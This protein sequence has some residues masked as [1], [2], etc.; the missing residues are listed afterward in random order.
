[1]KKTY[2]TLEFNTILSLI[3]EYCKSEQAKLAITNV[4]PITRYD[5]LI[6]Q[7]K[8]MQEAMDLIV[9]YGR[10]PIGPFYDISEIL[11]KANKDGT[12]AGEDFVR[13]RYQLDNV[14]E[15]V[16][17]IED[18]E[19]EDTTLYT[20]ITELYFIND[21]A[22]QITHCIDASGNVL[23]TASS[24][25]RRIRRA[26]L[27]TEANIRN[28]IVEMQ[29]VYK[30]LLSQETVA[31]RNNHLVLPVKASNKNNVKGIVHA[32]SASGQTMFIEPEAVAS[33][34]NQ[35]LHLESEEKQEVQRILFLLSQLVKQ[36][37][38]ILSTN[39]ELLVE[40]DVLFAKAMYGFS[41][42]G[43][44]PVIKE[45]GRS[46]RLQQARHPLIDKNEVVSNDIIISEDK[47]LLLISGSNTGGKTVVLK[48]AGLL[49]VMA[50]SGLAIPCREA[51]IPLFDDI[52]VDLGD[53]QSIEQSLSTFSSHM[54]RLVEITNLVTSKSLVLLDEIG[55]GT[56]PR[57]GESI[58]KA[59]LAYLHSKQVLT[60]AS[61][62]YSGLKEFA[63]EQDYTII[64][65]V[66][67][68]Q[69]KMKPTYR[70][71]T[72][73]VGNSY[74]I[75]ISSRLGLQ[76]EIVAS[77]YQYKEASLSASDKLLEKLQDELTSVQ[78]EKDD[79]DALMQETNKKQEK[80]TRLITTLEK[81]KEQVL[82]EAKQKANTLLEE[83][84]HQVD[85]VVEELKQQQEL[86]QHIVI[87]A[88]RT[89]DVLK[90]QEEKKGISSTSTHEYVVG[91]R[92]KILAMNREGEIISINKKGM[93]TIDIGGIKM[94]LK[95]QEVEFVAKKQKIK[96]VKSNIRS[97][98]KTTNQS[99]EINV[100]GQRYEEAMLHVDKFLDD[101]LVQNYSMVRIIHGVGTGVL[102]NGVRKLL[103]K[104]KNVVTY[105][106][107]GPNEGGLGA[108]LVY[109]E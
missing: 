94:S 76:K 74:A 20:K 28:K 51:V 40:L 82:Q 49:S 104:N 35:L 48:T 102:R 59:I 3:S 90:H 77:A 23:D 75:E 1:M 19:I 17:Y 10:L 13:I 89:L 31:S 87:D 83:A 38:P 61:T 16:H 39:Q 65:A 105:R 6:E 57:E 27:S 92:I 34:N 30:D 12:L 106:D 100:I 103:D 62:H 91:D 22:K 99:Y 93:L 56:D 73:N 4:G 29:G 44:V 95:P 109:F 84:K 33:M 46:L 68:D 101:A 21:L 81:Q 67:F 32:M 63:K 2:E 24:E 72:G 54:K 96:P 66:E 5:T 7:Q 45:E 36:Q 52:Y 79:L 86:K 58:A 47:T 97:L 43:I 85:E 41:I 26:I 55:S 53:E 60:I 15:I 80:Y 9:H 8:Y 25:L 88:K 71:L 50:L 37:Y 108:T 98:K 11:Q 18:K 70:L 64:A 69:E 107:G 42:E 14:K 78:K